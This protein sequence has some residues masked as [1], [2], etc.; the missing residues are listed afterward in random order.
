MM[1]ELDAKSELSNFRP[2]PAKIL[3][4]QINEEQLTILTVGDVLSYKNLL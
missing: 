4:L 3:G 1:V 2:F